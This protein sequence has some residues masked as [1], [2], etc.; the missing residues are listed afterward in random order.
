M[1]VVTQAYLSLLNS[2]QN[3]IYN[4][5]PDIVSSLSSGDHAVNEDMFES[6]MRFIFKFIEKVSAAPQ[7][8]HQTLTVPCFRNVKQK[9]SS[10][11]YVSASDW[12]L[13]SVNGATLLSASPFYHSSPTS[14][15]RSSWK[16]CLYIKTSCE[17]R[18]SI[19]ASS[20]SSPRFAFNAYTLF[21]SDAVFC[22]LGKRRDQTRQ[23]IRSLKLF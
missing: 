18:R 7:Q 1:Y 12:L 2:V 3:A 5:L 20:K 17:S 4:N 22:R 21:R 13:T 11:S 14:P 19:S 6:T 8:P 23:I 9:P 15:S 16:L 10:T